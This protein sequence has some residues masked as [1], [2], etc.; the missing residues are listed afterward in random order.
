MNPYASW[1]GG[2]EPLAVIRETPSRV[3]R[4]VQGSDPDKAWTPGKWSKRQILAHLADTEIAFA[5]RLRQTIAQD[6]HVIQP[7]D[8]DAWAK[9]YAD[10]PIEAA[11]AAFIAL[12]DWNVRFIQSLDD[13]DF[14][15]PVTHPE[16]G[17]G[18]FRTIVE[19]MA[20]HDLN[21]LAQLEQT[22]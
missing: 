16:R 14:D 3:R 15:K 1:L 13:A 17:T 8:Q 19:T 11:L 18:T 21:H 22:A 7:F 2:L 12:R 10:A 4:A 6:H 5:M 20:G 9:R